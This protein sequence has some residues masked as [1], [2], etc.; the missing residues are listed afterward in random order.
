MATVALPLAQR[1]TRLYGGLA[2]A[3]DRLQPLFA[4]A[5]RFYVA[6][7]FFLAGLTKIA[8]WSITLALF[9]NEYQVPLLSPE[10]AA[11]LG[12]FAELT[13]PVLLVAGLAS[14]F[15]AAA[16]FAVN[17]VAVISYPE[18]SDAGV[19]DH[20]LLGTLLAVTFLYGPGKLSLDHWFGARSR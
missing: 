2:R 14:R 12:T 13:L 7:V 17:I 11:A 16:L 1:A 3:I 4:F 6:R 15:T 18:I 8:D 9:E 19:K 10:L 5:I 20:I